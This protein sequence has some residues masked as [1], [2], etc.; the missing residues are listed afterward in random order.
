MESLLQKCYSSAPS[1]GG[2]PRKSS[3]LNSYS[4]T[5]RS[6][7]AVGVKENT[8]SQ[9][10]TNLTKTFFGM[11]NSRSVTSSDLVRSS[12]ELSR[13]HGFYRILRKWG[14]DFKGEDWWDFN[15]PAWASSVI[16]GFSCSGISGF[17]YLHPGLVL[18]VKSKSEWFFLA[19]WSYNVYNWMIRF[20]ACVLLALALIIFLFLLLWQSLS[21]GG[22]EVTQ[23]FHLELSTSQLLIV[24]TMTNCAS[25]Y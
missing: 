3:S 10:T 12:R 15:S 24:C 21:L 18:L 19:L 25:L 14:R 8:K 5:Q 20:S 4:S 17:L 13:K 1:E 22:R 11:V 16:G 7:L 2:F 23:M 9:H 6:N